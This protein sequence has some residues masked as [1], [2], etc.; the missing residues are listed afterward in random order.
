MAATIYDVARLAGVSPGTVSNVL[1][2]RPHVRDST[3]AKVLSA[4]DKLHYRTNTSARN[5]RS[6]RTGIITLAI[7]ELRLPYHADLTNSV[8]REAETHGWS[9]L[10]EQT[11]SDPVREFEALTGARRHL[12]D[13]LLLVR[14]MTSVLQKW[15]RPTSYP[16]VMLADPDEQV[17]IDV[18]GIDSES[19]SE[20][21]TRH[22]LEIGRRRVATIGGTSYDHEGFVAR[23]FRGHARALAEAGLAPDPRLTVD[24]S[25]FERH[26]GAAAMIELLDTGLEF[27]AVRCFNDALA[28]GAVAVLRER[29]YRIPEDVAVVGFDDIEESA[30]STPPLSSVSPNRPEVARTAV[31]MLHARL[32]GHAPAEPVQARIQHELKVRASTVGRRP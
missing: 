29:G 19:A 31:A 2:E 27:D 30:H 12:N 26:T 23:R 13:G 14:P 24:V 5:L 28:L 16:V 10:I 18:V 25:I 20:L 8:I 7:P 1:N 4:I 32:T 6:G 17:G 22:L 9:V 21:A 11:Y 15:T 3:R